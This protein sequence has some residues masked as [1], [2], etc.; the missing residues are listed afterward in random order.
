MR[1]S[2]ITGGE[3]ST[4]KISESSASTSANRTSLPWICFLA[5]LAFRELPSILEVAYLVP[6]R[7]LSH[8]PFLPVAPPPPSSV[9]ALIAPPSCYV[10]H[11]PQRP[12]ASINGIA[13]RTR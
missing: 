13:P 11:R 4:V 1:A 3:V 5:I 2:Q 7:V 10:I 9:A 12:D 8:T 6:P